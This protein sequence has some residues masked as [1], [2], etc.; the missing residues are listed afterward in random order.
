MRA[1]LFLLVVFRLADLN[2]RPDSIPSFQSLI[3]D[4]F[5]RSDP[6]SHPS[7]SSAQG[8]IAPAWRTKSKLLVPRPMP[9]KRHPE[10]V[11][12]RVVSIQCLWNRS[13][14]DGCPQ[15]N[16]WRAHDTVE[17]PQSPNPQP[18]VRGR[19]GKESS[20][21]RG[22]PWLTHHPASESFIHGLFSSFSFFFVSDSVPSQ[23]QWARAAGPIKSQAFSP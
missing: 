14:G 8:R 1:Q 6:F 12:C 10:N 4:P 19:L 5:T 11:Q 20:D 16:L 22:H 15:A 2:F 18:V 13:S 21:R 3:P 23:P 17:S 7:G 9:F